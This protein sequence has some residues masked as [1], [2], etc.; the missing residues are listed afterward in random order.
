MKAGTLRE[1]ASPTFIAN[2]R[3]VDGTHPSAAGHAE[4]ARLIDR[5]TA[6]RDW[7]P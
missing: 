2:T 7:L 5:W 3:S 6:R 4:W 1:S